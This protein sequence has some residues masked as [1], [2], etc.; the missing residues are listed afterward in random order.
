MNQLKTVLSIALLFMCASATRGQLLYR[1][2]GNGLSKPS[3]LMGTYHLAP[4]SFCDSIPGF[5]QAM[6]E[7][8][9]VCGELDMEEVKTPENTAKMLAAMTL[10]DGKTI[11]GLLDKEEM[12]SLNIFMKSLLG[13]DFSNPLIGEQLGKMSPAALTTQLSLMMYMKMNPNFSLENP[14]DNYVQSYG[15]EQG[16]KIAGLETV[17]DQIHALFTS[18]T[19]ERQLQLL[20]CM[21]HHR[22]YQMQLAG[23]IVSAYYA[24]DLRRIEELTDQKYNDECDSSP[25]E[26]DI[27]IYGRNANWAKSMPGMMMASPTFFAVGAA[28]LAGDKGLVCLLREK[29]Y[30]V[31]AVK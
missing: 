26:E 29:G 19:L 5:R 20:M 9:V 25:E 10:P 13:T 12:D 23:E 11:Q 27:L 14:I 28:H 4:S 16:K 6:S 18:Q 8:G 24:Q 30:L 21:V 15:K 3:Y 31:E 1:I 7:V 17:D 2:T 22:D